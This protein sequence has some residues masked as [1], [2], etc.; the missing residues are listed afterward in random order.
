M[1]KLSKPA[2]VPI[3]SYSSPADE[4]AL[5]VFAMAIKRVLFPRP[6]LRNR[7][8]AII[9]YALG[10]SRGRPTSP[11]SRSSAQSCSPPPGRSRRAKAPGQDSI[12]KGVVRGRLVRGG[13]CGR[14]SR[15]QRYLRVSAQPAISAQQL[16]VKPGTSEPPE[17]GP[18]PAQQCEDSSTRLV[19]Y[20]EE[21]VDGT[22]TTLAG[23]APAMKNSAAARLLLP[24]RLAH[25]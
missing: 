12:A 9:A 4:M 8:C 7:G 5:L 14:G 21:M 25:P 22:G 2:T 17:Y 24:S 16:R 6:A 23:A 3:I 1:Y 18:S 10:W 20:E 15:Q 19:L 11:R 13:F